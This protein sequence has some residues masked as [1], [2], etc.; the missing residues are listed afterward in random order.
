MYFPWMIIH[1][2]LIGFYKLISPITFPQ[3]RQQIEKFFLKSIII[4]PL[5]IFP[6]YYYYFPYRFPILEFNQRNFLPYPQ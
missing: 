1:F 4:T 5:R 3:I 2:P 6:I